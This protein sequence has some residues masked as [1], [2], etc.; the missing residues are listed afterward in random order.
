M[1]N[2]F[3]Y[4]YGSYSQEESDMGK[5]TIPAVLWMVFSWMLSTPVKAGEVKQPASR[6]AE[7]SVSPARVD[8]LPA[9]DAQRWVLKLTGPGGLF[10]RRAFEGGQTPSIDLF[11][12]EGE[13]LPDGGY[14]WE[15]REIPR[16]APPAKPVVLS[17]RFSVEQGRFVAAAANPPKPLSPDIA[18]KDLVNSGNLVVQGNACIGG[19]CASNDASVSV[20][21]LKST[22]PNIL[23]DDVDIPCEEV[24]CVS[25]AHD[26][27]LLINPSNVAQFALRDIDNNLTPFTVAAGAPDNSLFVDGTGKVGLGTATPSVSLHVSGSAGTTKEL[28][29]ETSATTAPR[30]LLELR[31]NGGALIITKDLSTPQRWSFGTFASAFIVD[32]QAHSGVELTLTNTGNLT[33]AGTLTQN[34]DR[35]TKTD[36]DPVRPEDIL[37]KVASLPISTWRLKADGPTVRHLGPMAQDFAAAFGLG[38][39]DRHIAPVDMAGVG[40]ASIQA[41]SRKVTSLETTKDAEIQTLRQE[42]AGLAKRVEAL[43]SLVARLAKERDSKARAEPAP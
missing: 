26:W 20:L 28:V 41:L 30:E 39:D 19:S 24:S 5:L 10:V 33:I 34:S 31:N 7:I 27:A 38:E 2:N 3:M 16:A 42:N 23:F 1:C 4:N 8:W 15:L 17:G 29:Q 6:V 18:E 14:G 32:E 12:E 40:L 37:A 9:V 36:I 43:E 11:N 22:Q 21:K 13:R 25:T 35:T